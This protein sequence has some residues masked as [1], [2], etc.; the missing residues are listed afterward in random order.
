MAIHVYSQRILSKVEDF[1]PH[2]VRFKNGVISALDVGPSR[3]EEAR[4]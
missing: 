3:H 2:S 1:F 4:S